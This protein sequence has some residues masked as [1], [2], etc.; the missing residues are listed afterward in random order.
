MKK[1]FFLLAFIP[2][3]VNANPIWLG[4]NISEIYFDESGEWTLEIDNVNIT[5][6][7]F[8]DSLFIECNSGL[9]KIIEFD[10][11]D[12]IVITKENLNNII[13][14]NKEED[15]IKLY[16]YAFGEYV[17][18]SV[19]VG[20]I[21]G[22]Y[23]KN[24]E[25]GQSISRLYGNGHFYKDNTPTI[26]SEN[27]LDGS[28]GKIYGY[29]YDTD[30]APVKNKYFF[31]NEG[32]CTPI[33]QEQGYAGNIKINETGFYCAEITSRSYSISEREIYE[34][35]TNY[36]L[37]QFQPVNFELNENDSIPVNFVVRGQEHEYVPFPTENVNWNV[38]YAG[39][40]EEA[41][42]DTILLRYTIH[43]D[44]SIN[45]IQYSKLCLETGDTINPKVRTIGGLR[46]SEKKIYYIG[47]T[48]Y[49]GGFE[50]EYL[51]Y[52]FTKQIGD[53]IKHDTYGGFYSVV[54]DIDSVLID[55]SFRKR[56]QVDNH[57]YYQNPDYIIEGI[58][59]VKN[60]L[61]GHISDI[62]TCGTHYWEHICFRENGIVKYLN[63]SFTDC[64]PGNLLSGIVQLDYETDFSIYPNPFSSEIQIENK[65]NH[66]NL[67]FKL[68]D[69]NGKTLIE[70]GIDN[71]K[72]TFDLNINSGIYNALIIDKNGGILIS[73]K[74]TKK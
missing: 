68:I 72:V 47:E 40:C 1:L 3:I 33:L 56:Y 19:C 4:V 50:D 60:G 66:Q 70:K 42:P 8:I 45:E 44:T 48:I 9:A 17:I 36:E 31:I 24:I 73:K 53:T 49:A 26:G 52:D 6:V 57:W 18:D 43:G 58:G 61:L 23:V 41:P 59:S 21:T 25:N 2:A 54:L 20:E 29:F 5:S 34:S 32:Y 7:E 16:S 62:P 28:T 63:P 11:T 55:D 22:S 51:L 71:V 39:T 67:I 10:T 15:C 65:L 69:I 64:F 27:D 35:S 74:L 38:F 14:F 46:E 37:M 12:Y 13:S 30:G